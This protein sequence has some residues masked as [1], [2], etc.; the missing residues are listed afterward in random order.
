MV[1]SR[2]EPLRIGNVLVGPPLVLAPMAGVTDSAYRRVMAEFGVGL[3]VSE[4]VSVQGLLR[5][6]PGSR[7]L[8]V[9]D[10][11]LPVP[12]AVQLFG[13]DPELMAEAARRVEAG[14]AA[15]IDVNA[16]CPVKKVI[17]QGA[18]ASLLGDPD[19]L[20]A[21]VEAMKKAVAVPVT[22][23]LR[24]GWDSE[25]IGVVDLAVRLAS[26]GADAISLH[27][28]TAVQHYSGE[29]DWSWIGKVK[30][31]VNV[32]VIGNGD[33]TSPALARKMLRETGCDAV[34]IGR[35]T[36]GNPWL[37]AAIAEDLGY[38][39]HCNSLPGW[40]DFSETV[41]GH[42]GAFCKSRPRCSGH[43]RKLL[44]W[45][46]KG[47]PDA[48]R[49]R[50]AVSGTDRP[51]EMLDIFRDWVRGLN[52]RGVS[53]LSSKVPAERPPGET[54]SPVAGLSGDSDPRVSLSG[55]A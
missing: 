17:R 50:T 20:A 3:V 15:L 26:A 5:G 51:E 1:R 53:F 24:L 25:S 47:C 30:K 52:D 44:L 33:V 39:V 6:Q 38:P 32:P 43:F 29:A 19:L 37:L 16:G 41:L 42:I 55:G 18:G 21:I 10:P 22:V 23:K 28:R 13:R 45:Y 49:L 35:A 8:C 14:G 31:A 48:V 40:E 7:E 46:S 9:Q 4:M 2:P 54:G 34:M 12:M 36:Q 11:P 27:A